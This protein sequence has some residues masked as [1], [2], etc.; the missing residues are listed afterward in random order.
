MTKEQIQHP[1]SVSIKIPTETWPL[2]AA[3]IEQMQMWTVLHF[4]SLW[5]LTSAWPL[6]AA[7][8]FCFLLWA[9]FSRPSAKDTI[10]CS[11]KLLF[12]DLFSIRKP[13]ER[14]QWLQIGVD[15]YSHSRLLNVRLIL[16]ASLQTKCSSAH[17]NSVKLELSPHQVPVENIYLGRVSLKAVTTGP[18]DQPAL[19]KNWLMMINMSTPKAR[20]G[21][22]WSTPFC[23]FV[24]WPQSQ[25]CLGLLVIHNGH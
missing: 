9:L 3:G 24:H 18:L 8:L 7:A 19:L 22:P 10:R 13:R 12:S 5:G 4:A 11:F 14:S 16:R 17:Q 20:L 1:S 15:A 25:L 23:Q 21:S 6:R 2:Q